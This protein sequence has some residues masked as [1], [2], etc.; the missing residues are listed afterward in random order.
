VGVASRKDRWE[1]LVIGRNLSGQAIAVNSFTV[2]GGVLA[3]PLLY[4]KVPIQRQSVAA[5]LHYNF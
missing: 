2:T 4:G 1:L 3:S 5:E